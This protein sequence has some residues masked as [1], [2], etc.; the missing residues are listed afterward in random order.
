MDKRPEITDYPMTD[1]RTFIK[2]DGSVDW[3]KYAK[4]LDEWIKENQ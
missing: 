1:S 3:E 4:A 2:L